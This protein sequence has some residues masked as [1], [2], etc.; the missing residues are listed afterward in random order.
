[1]K[2]ID[3]KANIISG[4]VVSFIIYIALAIAAGAAIYLVVKRAAG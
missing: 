2:K 3:R 1:M 4:E